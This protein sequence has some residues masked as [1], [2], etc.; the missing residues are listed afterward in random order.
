MRQLKIEQ[1]SED[2]RHPLMS[3]HVQHKLSW[4]LLLLLLPLLATTVGA[5]CD[6]DDAAAE[7]MDVSK[8][9]CENFHE[10]ACGNW[11]APYSLRALGAH[12][13]RTKL[14][15]LNKQQLVRHFEAQHDTQ[16]QLVSFYNSC[17]S[18]RQ[19]LH[20]YLDALQRTLPDWPLLNN[21]T[22]FQWARG[23]AAVR[24]FGAQGLWRL[25][26]QANW[27]AAE[28]RV[29]YV[30]APTFEL[31]GRDEQS[32]FLYQR[33][34]K[35]LLLE[36]GLRV[37]RA[38]SLATQLVDFERS[39]RELTPLPSDSAQNLV[40]HA[41]QTLQQLHAQL[42]QLQLDEY[43]RTLLGEADYTPQLLLVADV[44][45]LRRLQRVLATADPLVLSSWLL[46]QLPAHF[47]LHLH[48]DTLLAAQRERCLQQL[49]GLLPQQLSQLQLRLLHG[50]DEAADAFLQR[51]RVQLQQLFD[52]L[53]SQFERLLN[54]TPIFETD[55]ATR[56]LA[57][58]KLRAMRLLLPQT[59]QPPAT[60]TSTTTS[61][62]DYDANLL[63]LS[64]A[65]ARA[66]FRHALSCLQLPCEV[67]ATAAWDDH[68]LGPL[69]V[70]VYYKLKLNAIAL[71]LGLLRAPLLEDKLE[72]SCSNQTARARLLGG[73]GY[74][75]GHEML[76]AFD[77]DGINYDAA[78]RIGQWPPRAIIRFG[79]RAK[80][81]LGERYSNAT[82]TINENIADSEG[83]R[84]A[85]EAFREEHRGDKAAYRNFFVAFAQNWCGRSAAASS[86]SQQQHASHWERVNNVLSNYFEF[87]DAFDCKAGNLMH[88]P[89]KCRIW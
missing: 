26:V 82:L 75:L 58:D 34:L 30:L 44:E 11:H 48:E 10:H 71:P 66:Q 9:P 88:W 25:L 12:D 6:A 65:Q 87:F 37:R 68:S 27:Q 79:L 40:L 20:V 70:N 57:L 15:A 45:Y 28:Q 7:A 47:E 18:G 61:S 21:A 32:E 38:A 77:Y 39:L 24:R 49:N 35:Y 3:V 29:F 1:Q 74:M 73:L 55:A 14:R 56:N 83:L 67:G 43:F 81:F 5:G 8:S 16:E 64:E 89:E 72:G 33:Y 23:N 2:K 76:H 60:S 41:P 13:M 80:C 36:L 69:D 84:V 19:S 22:N 62:K 51:T 85:F 50:S 17:M 63:R 52:T 42:P 59:E 86:S 4:L 46:L 54:A 53:K 31:L 78:G